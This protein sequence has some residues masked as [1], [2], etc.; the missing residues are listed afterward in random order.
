MKIKSAL[1]AA[2]LAGTLVIAGGATSAFAQ[3][4]PR[5]TTDGARGEFVC[6]NLDQ[7]QQLQTERA[8]LVTDRLALLADA[9]VAAG[10]G[11]HTAAVARIDARRA[12]T[13][14]RQ[15]NV[16]ERQTALVDWA[17]VHC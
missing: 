1:T 4:A 13:A 14:E 8:T 3:S 7:I 6:A 17:A 9:R 2:G 12:R 15:A 16:A 5:P 10:A 11:G